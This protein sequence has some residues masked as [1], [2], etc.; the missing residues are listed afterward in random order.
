MSKY[1]KL[2]EWVGGL[3]YPED[4]VSLENNAE[5]RLNAVL[6]EI[7]D[8]VLRAVFEAYGL[9]RQGALGT[10]CDSC[11]SK[12]GKPCYGGGPMPAHAGRKD[13]AVSQARQ[14]L[15]AALEAWDETQAGHE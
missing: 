12:P 11:G 7:A 5:I 4:R 15:H 2:V 3:G 10:V 8:P 1:R 13:K 9:L 6:E 14:V